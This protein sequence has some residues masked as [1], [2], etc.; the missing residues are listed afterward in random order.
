MVQFSTDD[1]LRDRR[2]SPLFWLLVLAGSLALHLAVLLIGR[3]YLTQT[4][5]SQVAGASKAIEFVEVDP[6]ASISSQPPAIDNAN[7]NRIAPSNTTTESASSPQSAPPP[8]DAEPS[9]TASIQGFQTSPPP[10][11]SRPSPAPQPLEPSVTRPTQTRVPETPASTGQQPTNPE[12]DR[13]TPRPSPT[14][15]TSPPT[16]P[17]PPSSDE[18]PASPIPNPQTSPSPSV[19]G[20]QTDE[21]PNPPSTPNPQPSNPAPST[22]D[23]RPSD[24]STPEVPDSG[25]SGTPLP[26]VDSSGQQPLPSGAQTYQGQIVGQLTIPPFAGQTSAKSAVLVSPLQSFDIEPSQ[27]DS[28]RD[29]SGETV[30]ELRVNFSIDNETGEFLRINRIEDDSP[31]LLRRPE[32]DRSRLQEI[33]RNV[34][35]GTKYKVD[36]EPG[37]NG[38]ISPESDWVMLLQIN[39]TPAA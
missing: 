24:P 11:R 23:P 28:A 34:L 20:S 15:S 39:I 37:P 3:W 35:E 25:A 27:I 30:L 32:L 14:P 12:P 26:P 8:R 38:N 7:P 16:R 33:A 10:A 29:L 4:S 18:S 5:R 36:V 22:P 17:A 13:A 2:D 1:R 31:I 21:T 6:N 9:S 19:P